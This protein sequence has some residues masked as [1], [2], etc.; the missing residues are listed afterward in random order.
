MAEERRQITDP[1][2]LRALAHPLR[3]KLLEIIAR[4]GTAT[5]TQCAEETGESV[6]NCS[7]HLNTL[8]KYRYVE[9][10]GGGQGREKPWRLVSQSQ[11]WDNT[12]TDQE[13]SL[14]SNAATGAFL[15]YSMAQ[16]RD[17]HLAEY[18][19]PEEWQEALGVDNTNDYLTAAEVK[20]LRETVNELMNKYRGR[21]TDPSTRPEGA[22][23]VNLFFSTTVAPEKS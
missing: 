22:R 10:A 23:F 3:W 12:G 6:A 13:F 11:A 20:E 14:A 4:E 7:Y 15:D 18:L 17:R 16:I 9:H 5:A 2:A 1:K 19:E 21:R 8:A